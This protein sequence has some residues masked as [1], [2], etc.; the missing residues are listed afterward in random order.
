M[1]EQST[2][3]WQKRKKQGENTFRSLTYGMVPP[4]F[5]VGLHAS[6]NPSVFHR[7]P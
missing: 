6:V 1:V 3:M 5:G 4:T 7:H 2:H